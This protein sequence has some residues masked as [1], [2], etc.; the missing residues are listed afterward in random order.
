[1]TGLYVHSQRTPNT[2]ARARM[3]VRTSQTRAQDNLVPV[4][5][6]PHARQ[7]ELQTHSPPSHECRYT[8]TQEEH[9]HVSQIANITVMNT[10]S[11]MKLSKCEYTNQI[12]TK[13]HSQPCHEHN[14]TT[15]TNTPTTPRAFQSKYV[16]QHERA[17]QPKYKQEESC[18]EHDRQSTSANTNTTTS[19]TT[20]TS[21][22]SNRTRI[23]SEHFNQTTRESHIINTSTKS[24]TQVR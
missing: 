4:P 10:I 12:T 16:Y 23:T 20:S 15:S 18:Q 6:A 17:P 13:N 5:P 1:M 8:Q 7:N 19:H 22:H 3:Y 24:R 2:H 21:E 14:H 9:E 11:R